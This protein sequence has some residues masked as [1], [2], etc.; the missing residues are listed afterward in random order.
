MY[1][2]IVMISIYFEE[3][4]NGSQIDG[5]RERIENPSLVIE[6]DG[7]HVGNVQIARMEDDGVRLVEQQPVGR[8]LAVGHSATGRFERPGTQSEI[9]TGAAVVFRP[10]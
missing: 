8:R 2:Y 5:R 3:F 9:E 10:K 1:I 4:R 7:R 6:T